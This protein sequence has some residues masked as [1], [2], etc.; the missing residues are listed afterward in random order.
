MSVRASRPQLVG[1][2]AAVLLCVA[3]VPAFVLI[4]IR[5]LFGVSITAY[6]PFINDET[7]Y[8]HQAL[9]FSRVGFHG[10]YYPVDEVTNASGVTPFGPHGPGFAMLYG[11]LGSMFGPL[12][13]AGLIGSNLLAAHT[14]LQNLEALR[15][16]NFLRDRQ[17][18][19]E[20]QDAIAGKVAHRPDASRWCNT[21]LTSQYPSHL[22]AIP[23]GIGCK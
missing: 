16:D 8:W 4:L 3:S 11:T 14:M 20:L 19:V 1:R 23:A 12:L 18:P 15:R 2:V 17:G 9:T 6:H 10:G 21:L 22:I 7:A 13:A 5:T